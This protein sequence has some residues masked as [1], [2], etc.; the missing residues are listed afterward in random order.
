MPNLHVAERPPSPSSFAS[1]ETG[2]EFRWLGTSNPVF[3]VPYLIE[4]NE[5]L[6]AQHVLTFLAQGS[7]GY[8]RVKVKTEVTRDIR[9]GEY[10]LGINLARTPSREMPYTRY[11]YPGTEDPSH[12][13]VTIALPPDFYFLGPGA[14]CCIFVFRNTLQRIVTCAEAGCSELL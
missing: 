14:S 8:K 13:A 2:G 9:W 4:L 12:A 3:F 5:H 10:Y 1:E 11:F 6:R 7:P